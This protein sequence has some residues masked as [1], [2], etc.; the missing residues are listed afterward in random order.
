MRGGAQAQMM[1]C[2]DGHFYVVKF[3]NN[4]QHVRVLANELLATRIAARLGLPVPVV[5]VVGVG[6][7]LIAHTPELRIELAGQSLRCAAGLQFG[8]RFVVDPFAGQVFD[9][10]PQAMLPRVRNLETFAGVLAFDKWTCNANGRQAVYWRRPRE[11]K[12]T[13]SFVDQGYCFN[14]GEWS[15]PDA[16]LRGVYGWNDVYAAVTGWDSFQP[17]LRRI[18]EFS[19]ADFNACA[20]DLPPEWGVGWDELERLRERL[21][22]RRARVREL[23]AAFRFSTRQP[24]VNWSGGD[25]SAKEEANSN[26]QTAVSRPADC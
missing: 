14:A 4:P 16:P 6:E 5:E 19:A 15:F 25:L 12:Y 24:F 3:Q 8:A 26:Q 1:R 22:A 23:I 18:E 21:L 2:D 13:A 7:W 17:W 11:Q 10:L 9:Y 20:A